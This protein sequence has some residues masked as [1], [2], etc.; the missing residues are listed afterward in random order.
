[1]ELLEMKEVADSTLLKLEF[2]KP[3][4]NELVN[5]EEATEASTE[6]LDI[7]NHYKKRQDE[8]LVEMA[9]IEAVLPCAEEC[10]VHQLVGNGAGLC[11]TAS[12]YSAPTGNGCQ[13]C[14]INQFELKKRE[15]QE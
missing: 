4:V 1:M 9:N 8:I 5:P 6:W 2:A 7:Y 3:P 11:A 15:E 10:H 13:Y 14:L 12:R